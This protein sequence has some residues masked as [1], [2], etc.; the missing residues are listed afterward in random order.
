[1]TTAT[2]IIIASIAL[3][4]IFVI[5]FMVEFPY[6]YLTAG[7]IYVISAATDSLDGAIARKTGTVSNLGKILDPI[8]DKALSITAMICA[9]SAELFYYNVAFIVMVSV[10]IF[11]ELTISMM[12]LYVL[13]HGKALAADALGKFKTI[14]LNTALPVLV[15]SKQ[16]EQYELFN[17][18]SKWIGCALFIVAFALTVISGVNYLR[19]NK[20]ILTELR[21][22]ETNTVENQER[23]KDE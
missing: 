11:R 18:V 15:I 13:Y 2:K 3:I 9:V 5:T 7:I 20:K 6:H 1:M 10:M 12:R 19:V 21:E 17:R 4:P 22:N 8:A 16:F 23:G 14:F